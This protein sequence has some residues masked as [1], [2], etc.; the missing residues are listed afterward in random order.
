MVLFTGVAIVRERE[1]GNLEF[2]ITTPVR[3]T[4]LMAGK[5]APYILIG[6]FQIALILTLGHL[7]F[8]LPLRGDI[9]DLYVGALFF[10]AASLSLGL[11]ISTLAN[12]QFQTFQMS[13]FVIMPSILLSG[14]IFPYEGM[15]TWA[16]YAA[17]I[18]PMTHFVR[19]VR[20]IVLKGAELWEVA[21]EVGA[22]ALLF[23]I[24]F[25]LSVL[26]FRKRLD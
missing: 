6:L 7:L 23:A 13:F 1:R 26:R 17:E 20:A 9:A 10:I 19:I 8:R 25:T 2:L 16:Q 3:P 15:P 5:I 14:F 12:N 11:V 22:L 24:A 18:I 4:E 21:S